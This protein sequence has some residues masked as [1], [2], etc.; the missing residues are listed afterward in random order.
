METSQMQNADTMLVLFILSKDSIILGEF[1]EKKVYHAYREI[2]DRPVLGRTRMHV[3]RGI[4]P[5]R[6]VAVSRPSEMKAY[7]DQPSWIPQ[8][9][10]HPA[11]WR[12]STCGCSASVAKINGNGALLTLPSKNWQKILSYI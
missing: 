3:P 1:A 4:V 6:I 5:E 11:I 2:L 9:G 10:E 8:Q 12:G 7:L